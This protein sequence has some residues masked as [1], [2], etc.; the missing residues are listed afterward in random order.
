M[1]VIT[2]LHA[3]AWL[4]VYT[5]A[6]AAALLAA[7]L[8]RAGADGPKR[9]LAAREA[10][11][12]A[13][14][15]L[16]YVS[17]ALGLY[18]ALPDRGASLLAAVVNGAL[19]HALA[20]IALALYPFA[21]SLAGPVS[22]PLWATRALGKAGNAA[23]VL[24]GAGFGLATL[25]GAGPSSG[26]VAKA[27]A[28]APLA[29]VATGLTV[30]VGASAWRIVASREGAARVLALA[31]AAAYAAF[32]TFEL[33]PQFRASPSRASPPTYFALAA[34][35]AILNGG[36]ITLLLPR[37]GRAPEIAPSPGGPAI[38]GESPSEQR[39]LEAGLSAREREVA[40]LLAQGASYKDIGERLFVSMSTVQTHVTRVYAKLG[41]SSKV[42][43]ANALRRGEGIV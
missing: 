15:S 14:I 20:L 37:I 27:I 4:A 1:N 9:R 32:V 43:L 18:A 28:A 34:F 29:A 21:A 33:S 23:A 24:L 8:A 6:V 7:L 11:A 26:A 22:A 17:D 5:S 36:L 10:Y 31:G 16:A 30:A 42:E 38:A 35:F 13:F 40:T 3:A 39:M 19:L 25:L 2:G 12:V 41:V